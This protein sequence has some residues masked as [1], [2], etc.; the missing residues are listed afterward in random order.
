MKLRNPYFIENLF[1]DQPYS[2]LILVTPYCYGTCYKCQNKNLNNFDIK[3]FSLG[4]LMDEYKNNPFVD[5]VTVAGLEI[6]D[7]GDDFIT[8]LIILIKELH[9][10]K[11]T[12][13]SRYYLVDDVLS[14][15]VKKCIELDLEEFYVKTGE[16]I[17]NSNSKIIK[18]DNW[19]ITLASDNQNF[20]K[21]I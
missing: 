12:I 10:K 6:C 3:D 8:D 7:S 15:I 5:G 18:I 14:N 4:E 20:E 21:I 19:S 11:L 2:S 9:I 16:Y 13:Y 17:H 1:T